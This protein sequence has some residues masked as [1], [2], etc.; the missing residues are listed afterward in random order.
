MALGTFAALGPKISPSVALGAPLRIDIAA[1][2]FLG[3]LTLLPG[4]S[5][6]RRVGG[7]ANGVRALGAPLV[8][9]GLLGAAF[10]AP[11]A[12]FPWLVL[13]ALAIAWSGRGRI[14]KPGGRGLGLAVALLAA[15]VNSAVVA[16]ASSRGF[17]MSP[18]EFDAR[19]FR[20][21]SL[22]ADVP[23]H[24]AWAIDLKG[25]PSP[26]LEE[27]GSVFQGFSPF[28]ITPAIMGLGMLREVVNLAF[29]WDDPRWTDA[30]QSFVHRLSE[31]DRQHS[32]T[33]PGKTFGSWRVLYACPQEGVVETINGTVH[34]A[35][36]ATI[37]E[38]PDGPR[39]FLSFRVREVNW[40]TP[41]YLRM[42]DPARR[43]Y[44]YPLLLRQFAH[45][46]ERG[47]WKGA[48]ELHTGEEK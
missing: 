9:G 27:L 11:W 1:L 7:K 44:V 35:V 29:G 16:G 24:D 40:T 32:T 48:Y 26:T 39:L 6:R 31:T 17:R 19:D 43:F 30:T 36:A 41:F 13:P 2:A 42:I 47:G 21:N 20:I 12:T 10:V 45:S 3:V 28:Q 14:R 22:L 34:V 18:E 23:L 33:E 15:S 8:T 46:W 25:H 38:G 4:P 5:S 37:G